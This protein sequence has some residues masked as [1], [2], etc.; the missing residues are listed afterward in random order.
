MGKGKW[1]AKW[2][3]RNRICQSL[4]RCN[5]IKRE[6]TGKGK[7]KNGN[8]NAKTTSIQYIRQSVSQ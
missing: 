4:I 6:C 2:E 7:T 1:D 5:V 8:P 3:P